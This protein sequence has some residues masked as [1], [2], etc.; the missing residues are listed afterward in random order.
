MWVVH[1][2]MFFDAGSAFLYAFQTFAGAC[3][4]AVIAAQIGRGLF[5]FENRAALVRRKPKGSDV[6]AVTTARQAHFHCASR[7]AL[8][9][10]PEDRQS[11]K[12]GVPSSLAPSRS[13]SLVHSASSFAQ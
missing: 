1:A 10:R 2:Q 6:R 4:A 13:Y 3:R 8:R 7:I 5:T 11:L 12:L 9:L